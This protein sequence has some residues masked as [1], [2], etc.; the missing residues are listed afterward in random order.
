[1]IRSGYLRAVQSWLDAG[2]AARRAFARMMW[3]REYGRE[4]TQHA[5]ELFYQGWLAGS[6]HMFDK[7]HRHVE[8]LRRGL[9]T[10]V[11]RARE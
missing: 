8:S 7:T 3:E 11:K 2:D 1:M 5:W 6:T 9:K 10:A 4:E